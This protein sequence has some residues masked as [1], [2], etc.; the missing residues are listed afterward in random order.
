M[1]LTSTIIGMAL[2]SST[3]TAT[4]A[5][6]LDNLANMAERVASPEFKR[7]F[8]EFVRA[9]AKAANSF[10]TYR[11]EQGRLVQ[12]WPSTGRLEVLAAPVQ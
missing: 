11:D 5:Q 3:P 4:V 12:E 9:R 7:G 10:L 1:L 2:I 8:R 6:Q